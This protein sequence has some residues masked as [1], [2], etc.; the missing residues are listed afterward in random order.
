MGETWL[1][2]LDG[3]RG[4]TR[5]VVA[6]IPKPIFQFNRQFHDMFLDEARIG[7]LLEHPNIPRVEEFGTEQGIPFLVQE[8]VQGPKTTDL[9]Q[10]Q[11]AHQNVPERL[12]ARIGLDVAQALQYAFEAKNEAGERLR[13]I[14]RDV[15]SG[16]IL[17]SIK[18][19]A[20]LIDFGIA[21]YR[22][23]ETMTEAGVFKGKF[24]YMAP[25]IAIHGTSSNKSDVF[26]LGVVLY[27]LCAGRLPRD[28]NSESRQP[29]SPP[30]KWVPTIDP[31]LSKIVMRALLDDPRERSGTDQIIQSLEQWLETN[32]GPVTNSEFTEALDQL[33]PDRPWLLPMPL[34]RSPSVS[35]FP[36]SSSSSHHE[37][38]V[39]SYRPA[40]ADPPR[41][42]WTGVLILL[43]VALVLSSTAIGLLVGNAFQLDRW[44]ADPRTEESANPV[45]ERIVGRSR[46]LMAKQEFVSALDLLAIAA[47]ET[48]NAEQAAVVSQ[49]TQ[50][51]RRGQLRQDAQNALAVGLKDEGRKQ[52]N[53]LLAEF[54]SDEVGL[55]LFAQL[56]EKKPSKPRGNPA[57]IAYLQ[58]QVEPG[59]LIIVDGVVRGQTPMSALD[60]QPGAHAVSL[61][62]EGF[63]TVERQ[64][65]LKNG[66]TYTL[67]V[68][69]QASD[70][71]T[72]P[73]APREPAQE[74][75]PSPEHVEAATTQAG[76]A[77]EVEAASAT[78]PTPEST[79]DDGEGRRNIP[80][81]TSI[82][83]VVAIDSPAQLRKLLQQVVK[84]AVELEVPSGYARGSIRM[85]QQ[86]ATANPRPYK[87]HLPARFMSQRIVDG[88]FSDAE[89]RAMALDLKQVYL[90][91]VR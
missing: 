44:L 3:H 51:A 22:M 56:N 47:S 52:V 13:V 90:A 34:H 86:E 65:E 81:V 59:V 63:R 40:L 14:H 58:V 53:T 8:Y 87:Y 57:R 15:S 36:I 76:L 17:L 18:G 6:K 62:K 69:L 83:E 29:L 12:I 30:H 79:A 70:I 4:F 61:R 82:D 77:P 16:N 42:R 28:D 2:Q 75:P 66:S 67:D 60:L 71:V 54:P 38:T 88:Y 32:G 85:I 39:A 20:K 23:R 80:R 48:M 43:V 49:L 91:S 21:R 41:P 33:F 9:I 25:E 84:A 10:Q 24:A 78:V 50:D 19:R 31:H 11:R 74:L 26:S 89:P 46:T 37:Q 45:V 64:V 1:C 68:T 7:A 55:R 27:Q 72:A 35:P 5:L 73:V